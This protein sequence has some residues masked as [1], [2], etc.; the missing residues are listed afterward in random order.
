MD[1]GRNSYR[2][3]WT[4]Y[5]WNVTFQNLNEVWISSLAT[6]LSRFLGFL[7]GEHN[8]FTYNVCIV[9]RKVDE[10]LVEEIS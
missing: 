4:R 6:I 9:I 1:E 7:A 10:K 3:F 5:D 2:T 8:Q